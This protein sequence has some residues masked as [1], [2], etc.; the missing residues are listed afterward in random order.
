[1]TASRAIPYFLIVVFLLYMNCRSEVVPVILLQPGS[2]E[3]A[4]M[5]YELVPFRNRPAEIN[6][7]QNREDKRLHKRHEDVQNNKNHRY[8]KGH[9]RKEI[10]ELI[11]T[12]HE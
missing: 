3:T 12:S 6:N 2:R 7:R 1:S 10:S 5:P 8:Q 4:N 11:Q 9:R